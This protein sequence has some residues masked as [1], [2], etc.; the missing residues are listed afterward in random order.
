MTDVTFV[1]TAKGW[2]YLAV[3]LDLFSRRV[4]GWATSE[5]NDTALA[6]RTLELALQGRRP[7]GELVHH[8]DRGSP[9]ASEAY[10][11]RRAEAGLVG[12]MSR[13]GDCWDNAV[14]ESF[15]GTLKGERLDRESFATRAQATRVI[16]EYIDCFY[17]PTRRHSALGYFCP[18]E[19]EL[20]AHVATLAA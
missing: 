19:F 12:S 9:Y 3:I 5:T 6:L 8:S 16:G 4:V 11:A 2:L 14:A 1:R 18:I 10:R 15:F 7:R 20:K 17:N 13:A